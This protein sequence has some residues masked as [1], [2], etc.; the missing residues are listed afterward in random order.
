M[1]DVEN[2]EWD[3]KELA[4]IFTAC[5]P[6][7]LGREFGGGVTKW[8]VLTLSISSKPA[9]NLRC[10][11]SHKISRVISRALSR[12]FL[13]SGTR[14]QGPLNREFGINMP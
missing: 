11:F 14:N 2:G 4:E 10:I 3:K 8:S 1:I 13:L 12:G 5:S 6:A 7:V 9:T